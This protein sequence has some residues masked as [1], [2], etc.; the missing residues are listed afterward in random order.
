[1]GRKVLLGQIHPFFLGDPQKPQAFSEKHWCTNRSLK[2]L[3][4][5]G[6]KQGENNI[7]GL[8]VCAPDTKSQ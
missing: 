4:N 2:Q 1:M 3:A 8:S 6:R 5:R 7:F